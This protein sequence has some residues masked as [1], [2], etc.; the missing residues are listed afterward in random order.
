MVG[1]RGVYVVRHRLV[2]QPTR[3]DANTYELSFGAS[4]HQQLSSSWLGDASLSA[5]YFAESKFSLNYRLEL[6]PKIGV[7]RKFGLGPLAPVLQFDAGY[8][9]RSSRLVPDRGGTAEAGVR[10]AK[11]LNSSFKVALS[12]QWLEHYANS[13]T[14]DI[15]QR[16]LSAEVIWDVSERW[17]LSGTYGRSSGRVVANAAWSVWEQAIEGELGPAVFNYYNSIPWQITNS[18]GPLWVSYNVEAHVDQWSLA[19]DCA[20]SERTSLEFRYGGAYVVNEINIRYPTESWG[21][22]LVHRF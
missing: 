15:Q 21:L 16:T 14:F 20:L 22:G 8:T 12:G 3:K 6:G 13:A 1:G 5:D 17:R 2:G 4:H 18:Y 19:L 11:R 9:Y 10:L 7:Q